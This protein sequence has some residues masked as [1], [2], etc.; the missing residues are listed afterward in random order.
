MFEYPALYQTAGEMSAE[1]QAATLNLIRGEY[2]L[3]FL[4]AVLSMNWSKEPIFFVIYTG[5]LLGSLGLLIKRNSEKPEQG[6]YRG[7]A[8]A[9][10][11]KTSCWRYC[12]RAEPFGDADTVQTVKAEFRNHLLEILKTNRFIGDRM[13]PDS[14]AKEQIP[15]SMQYVR[16]LQLVDRKAFY[17]AHRIQEQ[18]EWYARKAGANKRAGRFWGKIG[19]FAYIV[20]IVL[21]LTRI[22]LP[23][24][25]LWPIEPV[26]VFASAIIGWTQVKKFN[27]LASSYA[28]TAHEI[29]IIQ[30]NIESVETEEALSDFI[31]E[32]ERAFS[33]EHTQWVAR[34]QS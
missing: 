15:D 25:E 30:G 22:A 31:N 34:Q 7:R 9:E 14:L 12:M 11:I 8:L 26:L 2:A 13:P 33:R 23:D 21:A 18:R 16:K 10:S 28:L 20:A 3:L 4:A 29:G 5:V 27:E 1:S 24:W 19:V 17:L 32:S 6:W